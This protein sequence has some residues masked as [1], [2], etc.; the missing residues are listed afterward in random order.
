MSEDKTDLDLYDLLQQA[1]AHYK[2][3]KNSGTWEPRVTGDEFAHDEFGL[4]DYDHFLRVYH[5][6][7]YDRLLN[8][9][10]RTPTWLGHAARR[11][12]P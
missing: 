11:D 2:G 7:V 5:K 6:D 4:S 9:P 12:T 3:A 10:W 8:P 1:S